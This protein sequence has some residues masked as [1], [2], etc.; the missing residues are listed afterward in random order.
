MPEDPT[1][2]KLYRAV[3][4]AELNDIT[5]FGI[6]RQEPNGHSYESKLF[7]PSAAVASAFGQDNSKLDEKLFF[8][9]EVPVEKSFVKRC[10][11]LDLDGRAAVNVPKEMLKAL[12]SAA[13]IDELIVH[14]AS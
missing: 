1:Y 14:S 7:A 11:H 12:N 4:S 6:F 5:Y 8:V 3:S 2:T 13:R 9:I 10:E